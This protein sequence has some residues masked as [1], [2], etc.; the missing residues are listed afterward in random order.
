MNEAAE[1]F[2]SGYFLFSCNHQVNNKNSFEK[3][4][5]HIIIPLVKDIKVL[6]RDRTES[7]V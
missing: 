1:A 2:S 7:A 4:K 6:L 3:N 5:W